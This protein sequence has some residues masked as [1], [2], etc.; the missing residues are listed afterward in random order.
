MSNERQDLVKFGPFCLDLKRPRLMRDG[1]MVALTPKAL[2]VLS[3]LVQNNGR[4]VEKEVLIR[5][6]WPDTF[7]EDG[8][9]SV[10]IFALR[11]ALAQASGGQSYIETIPRQGFRFTANVRPVD[12][13]SGN[14]ILERRR[15][16]Q[17]T[18]EE[19]EIDEYVVEPRQLAGP[20]T[21]WKHQKWIRIAALVL[22]LVGSLVGGT[23]W[24]RSKTPPKGSQAPAVRS[25]AVLPFKSLSPGADDEY[26]RVGV[27]DALITK[28][29]SV[30]Q[31]IVRPIS[32]TQRFA[33]SSEDPRV[34]GTNLGVEAIL[35]GHL[36]RDGDR[37]R[38]TVQLLRVGDGAQIWA[39][40]FDDVF[41]NIFTVQDSISDQVVQS[42]SI[43]LTPADARVLAKRATSSI[44]AYRSF[45]IGRHHLSK[46]TDEDVKKAIEYFKQAIDSGSIVCSRIWRTC[47]SLYSFE[48]LQRSTPARNFSKGQGGVQKGAR[49]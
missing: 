40:H 32:A 44:D 16:S 26:L 49:D 41:T 35:D 6:V 24:L 34:I 3:V 45:L 30:R 4:L 31:I 27:A 10:H 25:I 36:Q 43:T 8:N 28:L 13:N 7:V 11:K 33:N 47:G 46:R 48:L 20:S 37:I 21:S 29:G 9:L 2:E 5:Q 42:L 22:L 19:T 18:I 39:G 23:F 17:V 38:A 12:V 15:R 1:E 14:V